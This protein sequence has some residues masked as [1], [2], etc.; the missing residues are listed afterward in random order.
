ME[1][2]PSSPVEA[3]PPSISLSPP[4]FWANSAF[5]TVIIITSSSCSQRLI[6]HRRV[7]SGR[8]CWRVGP[9]TQKSNFG[10]LPTTDV[11]LAAVVA[12]LRKIIAMTTALARLPLCSATSRNDR[13]G[14]GANGATQFRRRLLGTICICADA[15][16]SDVRSRADAAYNVEKFELIGTLTALWGAKSKKK[17]RILS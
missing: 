7:T 1:L 16:L 10:R 8:A 12:V 4:R 17:L 11:E 2:I 15:R 5:A 13:N 3:G 14:R 6:I 9:T